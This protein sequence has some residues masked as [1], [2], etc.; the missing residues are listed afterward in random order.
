MLRE[1][2]SQAHDAA[3]RREAIVDTHVAWIDS[4]LSRRPARILDLACGPG[5]YASRLARLGHECTGVDYSPASIQYART[6]AERDNLSCSYVQE[7]LR[8]AA[9]GED[10][11]L[12]MLISGE[13]NVFR[14]ADAHR[15][16]AKVR[17]ALSTDGKLLL[18]VHPLDAVRSRGGRGRSWYASNGGLFSDSPHVCLQEHVWHEDTHTACVRYIIL[19][20]EGADVSVYGQTFQAYTD[21]GLRSLLRDCGF[22]DVESVAS[23]TGDARDISLEFVV[24]VAQTGS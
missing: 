4:L 1:H 8:A 2:L 20:N 12:V 16:L 19:G 17:D 6:I 22:D 5:L 24:L 14:P 21:D 23:L 9:F 18:E 3:S 15:I 13:L 10:F 11:D 7:D